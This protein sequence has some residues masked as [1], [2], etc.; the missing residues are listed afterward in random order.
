MKKKNNQR[1]GTLFSPELGEIIRRL[2]DKD[3]LF[4]EIV[5]RGSGSADDLR[6]GDGEPEPE[7][8]VDD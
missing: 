7:P 6:E 5:Q 1:S 2:K 3:P 8:P 4:D